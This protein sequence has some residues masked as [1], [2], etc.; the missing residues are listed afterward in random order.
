MIYKPGFI[1]TDSGIK[2]LMSAET[3]SEWW[4]RMF[5]CM[6]SYQ[7]R[8]ANIYKGLWLWCVTLRINGFV[9]FVKSPGS[10]NN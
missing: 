6:F 5:I 2:K 8:Q 7:K 1:K 9:E 10:L 3:H 4:F